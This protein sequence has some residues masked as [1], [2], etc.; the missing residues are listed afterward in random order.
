MASYNIG[1]PSDMK[2]FQKDMKSAILDKAKGAILSDGIEVE[3]PKCKAKFHATSGENACP[4]CGSQI[5]LQL[6]FDF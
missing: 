3:C 6:D 4:K 1:K 5:A 2:K